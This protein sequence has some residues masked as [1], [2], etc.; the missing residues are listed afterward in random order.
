MKKTTE[1]AGGF[2]LTELAVVLVIVSLL[3]GGLMIPLGAQKGIEARRATSQA[4]TSIN[5]ALLGFAI[6][7]GRLPCPADGSIA[8][9]TANA[10]LEAYNGSRCT[11][12]GSTA[13]Y[14][15]PTQCADGSTVGGTLP[16]TTLGLP[17]TDAWNNRYTY[18]VTTTYARRGSGQ[19]SFYCDAALTAPVTSN[20][21]MAL[22]S[23]GLITVRNASGTLLTTSNE[24]PA[25]VLSHG[26]NGLGA[27]T[28]TGTITPG[29]S[30]NELEN[31]DNNTQFVSDTSLDDMLMWISR[32]IL[33]SRLVSTGKLP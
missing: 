10:G 28:T 13:A 16:S 29:A 26:E 7:H 2:T 6:T 9:G 8:A 24:V 4:M 21:A 25:I 17:D 27:W 5:E 14:G 15:S 18:R 22:C 30:G 33:M 11:C 20:A 3:L 12:A 32:S 23:S 19:T 1:R 31:A